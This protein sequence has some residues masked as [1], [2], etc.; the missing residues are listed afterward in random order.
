MNK[1]EIRLSHNEGF[2]R[3][4]KDFRNRESSLNLGYDTRTGKS[5]SISYGM[6]RNYDDDMKILR[7][8]L[9]LKINDAWNIQYGLTRLWLKPDLETRS[10]WI[11]LIR[12]NYYFNK[13]LFLKFFFQTSS[14][15][16]KK[17]I[18]VVFV[19]RFLPPFG[20]LQLAY[21]KGTSK[22]GTKS[23]QGNTFFTKLSWV[24]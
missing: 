20:S 16:D 4:E 5:F 12:S 17:N 24:F 23:D 13:D 8:N 3:Y 9:Q 19:W 22:F 6:G 7:G 18:Q 1:W 2:K 21:Q 11:H 10:T 15:L 14:V